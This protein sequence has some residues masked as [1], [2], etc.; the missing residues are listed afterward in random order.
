MSTF[1]QLAVS[2]IA[3]GSIYGLIALG[4]LV[5]YHATGLVNFA[6]GQLLM[7]G[8]MTTYLLL[9][10]AGLGYPLAI[11][12]VVVVAL[13][14][15]VVFRYGLHRPMVKRGA[16]TTNVVVATIAFGLVLTAAAELFIGN[17]KYGVD[18]LFPGAPVAIG[19]ISIQTQSLVIVI[20]AWA[21]VAAI[22]LFFTKTLTGLSLR[23][24]GLNRNAAAVSGVRVS[25]LI[26]IAFV[27]SVIVTVLGGMLVAP[28]IGAGPEMGLSIAVKGFAAAVIGG[29]SS[30]YRG[31]VAGVV[32]GLIE[33]LSSYYVSSA[34]APVIAYAILFI[35]L[36]LMPARV[37]QSGATA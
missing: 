32:I 10:K 20:V 13:V 36:V 14:L 26:T 16:P 4:F 19:D 8:A 12:G 2:G 15:A 6:Q 1:L 21:L 9:M 5:I 22:W 34:Y 28:L 25:R 33:M 11:V 31:M 23:A 18:P 37:R 35:A 24:V 27:I 7:A 30:V 29:M 17:T 3:L